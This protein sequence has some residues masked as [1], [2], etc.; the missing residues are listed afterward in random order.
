MNDSI[1]IA[2]EHAAPCLLPVLPVLPDPA[3]P[4]AAL[5]DF[6]QTDLDLIDP[7]PPAPAAKLPASR[8]RGRGASPK[9]DLPRERLLKQGPNV[10]SNAD[11]I[12]VMLCTG[13]TGHSVF[14]MAR[15]LVGRFGSMRAILTATE[16]D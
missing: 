9:D 11:L 15:T 7:A 14:E 5:P 12:A 6:A 1:C 4:D 16:K 3:L 2:R 8:R 13:Q 10:L